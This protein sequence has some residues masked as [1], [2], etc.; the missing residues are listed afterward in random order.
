MDAIFYFYEQ[1]ETEKP[2]ISM[3]YR[4]QSLLIKVGLWVEK[5][6][7]C[8]ITVLQPPGNSE[9]KKRG[10]FTKKQR[11]QY[12]EAERRLWENMQS[13]VNLLL[14]RVDAV[15]KNL[16]WHCVYEES[17]QWLC[18]GREELAK[19]WRLVWTVPEFTEY[20]EKKW[21]IPLLCQI[22]QSHF[23]I[24][25]AS[26]YL[27]EV[28]TTV[29]PK[30]K[31]ICWILNRSGIRYGK[32]DDYMTD[33]WIE[34]IT[35]DFY[36]EYG[37]AIQLETSE[38]GLRQALN[39]SKRICVLDFVRESLYERNKGDTGKEY[40]MTL[41]DI[42][43]QGSLW[44]DFGSKEARRRQIEKQGKGFTYAS[45]KQYW[46]DCRR[47]AT[48]VTDFRRPDSLPEFPGFFRVRK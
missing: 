23:V 27:W 43:S 21:V 39:S 17:L 26:P 7:W 36:I 44:L 6:C 30:A 18:Q 34:N 1:K 13:F 28:L 14:N 10:E 8:G 4:Q 29:A 40:D 38:A 16:D 12:R 46:K 47:E 42:V 25:G 22:N 24:L 9:G 2:I 19:L 35:E 41:P 33:E 5:S 37:L 20:G 15:D 3:M 31:S 32:N 11:S 45:L 48:I